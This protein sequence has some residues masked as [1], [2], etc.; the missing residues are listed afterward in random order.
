MRLGLR[1]ITHTRG[2][3]I[4]KRGEAI[5]MHGEATGLGEGDGAPVGR[6]S[7]EALLYELRSAWLELPWAPRLRLGLRPMACE[8][9]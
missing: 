6:S 8:L 7:V 1:P 4:G 5:G 9:S 3:A 2:E